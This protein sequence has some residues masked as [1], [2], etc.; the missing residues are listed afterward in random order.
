MASNELFND[1][2]IAACLYDGY[3]DSCHKSLEADEIQEIS[4]RSGDRV[5]YYCFSR[6]C[7][8]AVVYMLCEYDSF[9]ANRPYYGLQRIGK[10]ILED[11][12]D[13]E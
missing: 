8:E 3:C 1:E 13:R 4:D 12:R 10:K 9:P 5:A 11:N 2:F 6:V 7:Y